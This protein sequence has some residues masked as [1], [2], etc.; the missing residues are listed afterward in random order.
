MAQV[1][2]GSSG[3]GEG[4]G[5]IWGVL[6]GACNRTVIIL[7]LLTDYSKPKSLE[8]TALRVH[9]AVSGKWVTRPRSQAGPPLPV[10]S[11]TFT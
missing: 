1:S 5:C 2:W 7:L 3:D 8:H 11:L 6:G 9:E 4:P 10:T